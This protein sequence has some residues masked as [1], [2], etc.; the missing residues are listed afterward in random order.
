MFKF[1]KIALALTLCLTSLT[2]FSQSTKYPGVGRDA[3]AKEVAAWDI[4]VRPDFK[5]L[6]AGSGSVAKGQDVWE[7]KCAQCHGIFGESNE[8]FSP[9]IGGT[10]AQDIK[11]GRVAN[12]TRADFPGRTTIMKVAT[13]STLWDYINRAMPWTNPKTLTTEEVYAVT[14]FLLNLAGIVPDDFVLSNKNMAEVQKRMPNRNGMTV[15]TPLWDVKGKGDVQ[16][17]A[18]MKNCATE[19]TLGSSLPDFARD[20]HGDIN[21]QN[22]LIGPVRGSVTTEPAPKT[23]ADARAKVTGAAS[24]PK[25]DGGGIDVK[26]L[27]V[28]NSCT[29]CHGM[30]TKMVGPGFAEV[31]EKYK[32]QADA[33]AYL[34]GKIKNGGAGVWGAIPMPP[35]PQISDEDRLILVR[36]MLTGQ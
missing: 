27:L 10:T 12:L 13:V 21:Q 35:Q 14:G 3:T 4:D 31:A 18:C 6:P 33:K 22:R 16:N 23:L 9:L 29:A 15:F 2:V 36:W 17:V 20:A 1:P 8:V 25:A 11:T 28:S 19:L 30:K 26:A 32:G 24:A 7:A 34:A 5:G